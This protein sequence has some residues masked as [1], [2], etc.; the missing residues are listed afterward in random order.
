MGNAVETT[1]AD[2]PRF[3]SRR[4]GPADREHLRA[5][6][7]VPFEQRI[8]NMLHMQRHIMETVRAQLADRYPDLTERELTLRVFEELDRRDRGAQRWYSRRQT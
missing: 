2:Q 4:W 8:L 5:L 1:G 6:G 3:T 7:K